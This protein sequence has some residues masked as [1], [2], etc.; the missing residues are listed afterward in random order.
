MPEVCAVRWSYSSSGSNLLRMSS[1]TARWLAAVSTALFV[2]T[3][4]LWLWSETFFF[5]RIYSSRFYVVVPSRSQPFYGTQYLGIPFCMATDPNEMYLET[6][7][8]QKHFAGFQYVAGSQQSVF[9]MPVLVL[10]IVPLIGMA[11][12]YTLIYRQR[13]RARTGCCVVCGYD[14]R[15]S[16]ERCPECGTAVAKLEA[17][18]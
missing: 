5:F 9:S 11:M 10:A 12:G 16:S 1:R 7:T 18:N 17:A 14:L 2:L 6:Q 4:G 15:H 13:R 8:A 3:L